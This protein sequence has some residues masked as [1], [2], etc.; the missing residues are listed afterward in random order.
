MTTFFLIVLLV[1]LLFLHQRTG[2]KM[3]LLE[4]SIADLRL[5]LKQLED[6]VDLPPAPPV[7]TEVPAP[8]I[9]APPKVP[10]EAPPVVAPPMLEN[11]IAN[12]QVPSQ[13][14][15]PLPSPP[16]LSKA[17]HFHKKKAEPTSPPKQT[18]PKQPKS[19]FQWRPLLEKI[20]L[21]PPTGENAEATIAA[22]WLTRIGLI[23]M[24][25]AAVFFGVRIAEN[26]PP[27]LRL[28]TLAAISVGVALLGSW[29]EKKLT[30]F[31]RLI[32]AGGLGLGYF[33]AFAAYGVEATKVIDNPAVGFFVQT[34]AIGVVIVWSLWKRDE[35]IAAMAVL[36]GFVACW[37]SHHHDLDHFVIAGLLFLATGS[38]I[39]LAMRL[40]MWPYAVGTAGAW[41]GFLILGVSDWP[42]SGQAPSF[43]IML[44]SLAFL[45]IILE[46]ANFLTQQRLPADAPVIKARQLRWMAVINTTL[47]VG[48]GWLA[49]RLAFPKIV[50]RGQLDAFY[51]SFAGIFA[52]FTALRFWQKHPVALTE[53]YFL[54]SSGL[55]ALFVVAYF[56]GPTRW[57]SLSVQTLILLVAWRR[58]QLKWVEAGFGAL[59]VASLAVFWHDAANP[60]SSD[61]CQFFSM[62]HFIGI[63]SMLVLTSTLA[64][65]ARWAPV[66]A[67]AGPKK[68]LDGLLTDL[69]PRA[70]ARFFA[71]IGVGIAILIMVFSTVQGTT[72]TGVILL[73]S[74]AALIIAIPAVVWR[75]FPPI[76]A[77]L[78]VLVPSFLTFFQLQSIHSKSPDAL[79]TGAW[80][81]LLGLGLAEAALRLWKN[82]WALGNLIRFLLNSLGLTALAITLTRAL[83]GSS[84]S[85]TLQILALGSIAFAGSWSLI[86]QGQH[87]PSDHFSKNL[88]TS[89]LLQWLLAGIA[90]ALTAAF[91]HE[92]LDHL[93]YETSFVALAAVFLFGSA[94]FSRNASAALAGGIPLLS[95]VAGYLMAFDDSVFF[96]QHLTAAALIIA[97]CSAVAIALKGSVNA[98][99]HPS[100]VWFDAIL[101]GLSILV[102]H[103]LLRWNL[104]ISEVFFADAILALSLLG[105]YRAYPFPALAMVSAFPLILGMLHGFTGN[106]FHRD[107]GAQWLWTAATIVIGA[108]LWLGHRWFHRNDQSTLSSPV[109]R[110]FFICH[111]VVATV[112]LTIAGSRA[113]DHPWHLDSLALVG[114]AIAC[115]GRWQK[116]PT[117][118]WLSIFPLALAM[119]GAG[120]RI[121]RHGVT[122]PTETLIAISVAAVVLIAHGV[123]MTWREPKARRSL[124]WIHALLY[125]GIVFPAFA[126]DHF[127]IDSLTTVC[128]G[129]AAIVLFIVGLIAGLRPYRLA[130]LIGL[131][132]TMIRMFA[133]DIDDSHYRIY[134][135]FALAAALL[136]VGYLYHRFRHLIERADRVAES[137]D[138]ST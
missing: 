56:D 58:S 89:S 138:A 94:Y 121:L 46:A 32:S 74:I 119:S 67:G 34:F 16:T 97:V 91:G 98:N 112:A 116:L 90:G 130:A 61:V 44:G 75:R 9:Q 45:T 15:P 76:V 12:A 5:R 3:E 51:L 88:A 114:L 93:V 83:E 28:A 31:G 22:W 73:L 117:S 2:E 47:A 71:G 95:A 104:D 99:K 102:F 30:A 1:V 24:I 48:V 11:P 36:L 42:R 59:F 92:L 108:W 78:T 84:H 127:G 134:A 106:L 7:A 123:V 64:L 35:A 18:P 49:I 23:I 55:L 68:D 20:K 118:L 53:T 101:H 52:G 19:E 132:M 85:L 86:R 105:I 54:K 79:W 62:R 57:L 107:L 37:F 109:R 13:T 120:D 125:L 126:A 87:F 111:E 129:V 103:W 137:S 14:P 26:T 113:L 8:E 6:N 115:L 70:V 110:G 41:I 136:G 72:G 82:D 80:L 122:D 131:A 128:W 124:S 40:W 38:G 27:E 39:L 33:T 133:V 63:L 65:H 96:G 77:G 21:W 66:V 69:E 4:R 17:Q 81:S 135:S 60:A 25:I 29:L 50:E 100:A 10:D 43:E